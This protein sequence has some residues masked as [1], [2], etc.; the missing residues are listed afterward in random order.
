MHVSFSVIGQGYGL[1]RS[2]NTGE[3][4][5][6]L[7]DL[8]ANLKVLSAI[9]VSPSMSGSFSIPM[10]KKYP[11]ELGGY[12]PVAPV[13]TGALVSVASDIQVRES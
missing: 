1:T 6:Y 10:I 3:A 2:R 11:Q 5:D 13:G 8:L 4:A 12:V 7:K 9:L